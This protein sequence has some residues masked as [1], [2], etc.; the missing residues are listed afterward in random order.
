MAERCSKVLLSGYIE[1]QCY[2]KAVVCRNGKWYCKQHDPGDPEKDQTW[3]HASALSYR[4]DPVQ[5]L[6]AT[7]ST[8]LVK[9]GRR[10]HKNG[11]YEWICPTFEEAKACI[12]DY[13]EREVTQYAR[14][15]ER[16]EQDL[17]AARKLEEPK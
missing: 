5:V 17:A 2:R 6:S 14:R 15:L 7:K 16:A 13:L 12:V 10:K 8:V 11:E 4:I 1:H 9:G 3:W